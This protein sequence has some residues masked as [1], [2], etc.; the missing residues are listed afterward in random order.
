V[1]GI[2]QQLYDI[3]GGRSVE[4][5]L[6]NAALILAS[7]IA[8]GGSGCRDDEFIEVSPGLREPCTA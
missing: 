4:K 2:D 5:D 8:G 3:D 1:G 7:H 6:A